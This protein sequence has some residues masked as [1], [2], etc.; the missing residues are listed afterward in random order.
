MSGGGIAGYPPSPFL[1]NLY[2]LQGGITNASGV[3]TTSALSNAVS[4]LQQMVDYGQKRIY[5]N[6]ISKYDTSPIQ[7][8]DP[9]TLLSNIQCT[10]LTADTT[11]VFGGSVTAASFVQPSDA[12][13]KE[14]VSPIG[15]AGDVVDHLRG[16]TFRWRENGAE[17]C[18]FLAQD[19]A[20]VLP[21]AVGSCLFGSD[22][23]LTVSYDKIIPY[24][25]E[26]VK[27]LRVRVAG[28]EKRLEEKG[29]TAG[30]Q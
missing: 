15:D 10:S 18:G 28:L 5:V 1:V 9:M 19:V 22:V 2:D 26:T 4:N 25:V 8:T 16:V 20:P 24:L 11:G 27:D 3:T 12:R 14:A 30:T 17:D 21:V 6:T 23:R 7:V 13:L 29:D